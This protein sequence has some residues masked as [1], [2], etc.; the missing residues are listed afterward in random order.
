MLH[1][2]LDVVLGHAGHN[3]LEP[4][5]VFLTIAV[6]ANTGSSLTGVV[7]TLNPTTADPASPVT[8]HPNVLSIK[9]DI[10]ELPTAGGPMVESRDRIHHAQ[11]ALDNIDTMKQLLDLLP[12]PS[13]VRT[14]LVSRDLTLLSSTLYHL[15]LLSPSSFVFVDICYGYV[16]HPA[17]SFLF[18][19]CFST[20]V[21]T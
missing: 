12:P 8:T 4:A 19:V 3:T 2:E 7:N 13:L 5:T 1:E 15:T 11:E 14:C 16:G 18:S 17:H 10:T 9:R 21:M 20:C 6:S